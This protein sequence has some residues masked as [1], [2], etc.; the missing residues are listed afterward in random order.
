M[1]VIGISNRTRYWQH[2]V[3]SDAPEGYRYA[4]MLDIPWHVLKVR[5]Q[6]LAHTKLF[7]PPKRADIYHTYNSVVVNRAPWVIEVESYLPRYKPMRETHPLYKWALRRLAGD[8]CKAILYTSAYTA[9]MNRDKLISAG[10]DPA[11]M[12]VLYR[13]VEQ[14]APGERD[15]RHFTILFAGNGFYRKGGVELLKAFQRLDR[16]EA[17]LWIISTLEVD[18][19]VE[20]SADVI[21]YAERTIVGDE[22]ITLHRGLPHDQVTALMRKSDVFVSTTFADPFNNTIL[23]AMGCQV[24]IICSDISSL[25]EIV[26]HGRNGWLLPVKDRSSDEIAED[27]SAHLRKLIDDSMMRAHMSKASLDVVRERFDLRVRNAR[28]KELYDGILG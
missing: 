25:P 3:F 13:A 27:I 23:E 14:F 6:F 2:F 20:P 22:R 26:A 24:P 11:K 8:D 10:V 19:G 9:A 16:P 12:Q 21:A 28:L 17:R 4:R 18:W 1:R 7:L 5:N 15:P